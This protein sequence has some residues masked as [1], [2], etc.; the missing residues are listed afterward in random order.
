MS[1]RE[2]VAGPETMPRPPVSTLSD[3]EALRRWL[4]DACCWHRQSRAG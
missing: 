1:G 3:R 4:L 2:T